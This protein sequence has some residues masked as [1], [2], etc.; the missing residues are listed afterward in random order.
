MDLTSKHIKWCWDNGIYFVPEA[1]D[2]RGYKV[3]IAMVKDGRSKLGSE[4][5]PQ[6]TKQDKEKLYQKI[7]SLYQ[8]VF[9]KN[10]NSGLVA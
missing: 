8:T 5:Y 2:D 3:K 10:I 9:E 4:K 1:I 7:N 6:K